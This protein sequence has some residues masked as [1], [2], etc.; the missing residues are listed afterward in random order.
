MKNQRKILVAEDDGNDVFL[1]RHA[2]DV[3]GLLHTIIDVP[4]GQ[5]AVDYLSA[6]SPY[7][8]RSQYPL[9]NLLLLDLKMPKMSGFEILSWLRSQ[10]AF[11]KLPV[12]VW[13][14]SV[15]EEDKNKA[16]S[17]GAKEYFLKPSSAEEWVKFASELDGQWITRT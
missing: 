2:F 14:S 16:L 7:S 9:P 17:L 12:V 13:S 1:L 15:L 10:P 11:S 8:D 3:V 5:L 6:K 4:D